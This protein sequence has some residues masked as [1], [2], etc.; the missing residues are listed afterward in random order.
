MR[1]EKILV[2]EFEESSLSS[3]LEALQTEGFQVV[4]AKDGHEGLL[5]F[6]S[7]KPDL[8]ILEPMLLKLHGFDLCRKISKD[9][10]KK[11]PVIITTGFYKGEHYKSEAIETFG[12]S[13]F[14][15]KPYKN[16]DLMTTIHELLGNGTAESVKEIRKSVQEKK[17]PSIDIEESVKEMERSIREQEATL[18]M[19]AKKTAA[20]TKKKEKSGI[21]TQVDE[22]L[23]DALSDF[24]L[25]IEKK[26]QEKVSGKRPKQEPSAAMQTTPD[27]EKKQEEEGQEIVMQEEDAEPDTETELK[28]EELIEELIQKEEKTEQE[29]E[30]KKVEKPEKV[31][32]PEAKVVPQEPEGKLDVLEDKEDEL[33]EK[34]KGEHK[35]EDQKIFEDYFGEPEKAP[36]RK[37]PFGFLK[38]IKKSLPLMIGSTAFIVLIAVGATLIFLK[39]SKPQTLANQK[40]METISEVKRSTP[41]IEQEYSSSP[42]T[43]DENAQSEVSGGPTLGGEE[44]TRAENKTPN[45]G[46]VAPEKEPESTAEFMSTTGLSS[47]QRQVMLPEVEVSP[48]S[49][50]FEIIEV[51]ETGAEQLGQSNVEISSPQLEEAVKNIIQSENTS[52]RIKVGDLVPIE[53]V[54][55]PPVATKKINPKYPPA[56]FQRGIEETVVFRALI[57]EFGNVLDVIFVDPDKTVAAFKKSCDEAVRQWRFSPAKKDGVNVKVWKT[58]SIAFKKNITE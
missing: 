8:V 25:N 26:P 27:V 3:L 57:S 45:D 29:A 5:M 6:E 31:K 56:A 15:E 48:E 44:G 35:E 53:T 36:V 2:V 22:M 18:E 4:T 52:D 34:I 43:Q 49:R 12:A 58:F 30:P 21:S 47:Q 10:N 14:F 37:K 55:M 33:K 7:E 32:K 11:T 38:K 19:Q 16:E 54:D 41:P 46:I 1:N 23:Q 28:T 13:A 50:Q 17:A 20:S 24:G 39:P 51:E 9:S 40:K 42:A